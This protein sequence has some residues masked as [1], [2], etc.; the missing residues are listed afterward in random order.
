MESGE[1]QN[2]GRAFNK[3][4]SKHGLQLMMRII[5]TMNYNQSAHEREIEDAKNST[6]DMK[7]IMLSYGLPS[8]KV[9]KP[10]EVEKYAKTSG[11]S[12]ILKT[13][14]EL[15]L[16]KLSNLALRYVLHKKEFVKFCKYCSSA[17]LLVTSIN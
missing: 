9:S 11:L 13:Q 12:E 14:K 4:V 17:F 6:P 15:S 2:K 8:T 5:N 10:E 16:K 7:N 1:L 3:K